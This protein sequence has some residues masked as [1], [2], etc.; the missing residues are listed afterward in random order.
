MLRISVVSLLVLLFFT[1]CKPKQSEEEKEAIAKQAHV[2]ERNPV[3]VMVLKKTT[4]QK[5]LLF[6]SL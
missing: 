2:A 3:E 1:Q 4:F 6:S 5:E